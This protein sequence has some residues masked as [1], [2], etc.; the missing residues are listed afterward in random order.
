VLTSWLQ[1]LFRCTEGFAAPLPAIQLCISGTGH[2]S[3]SKPYSM[4]QQG[5]IGQCAVYCVRFLPLLP[6]VHIFTKT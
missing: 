6:I 1:L 4:L 3:L 5:K 2:A